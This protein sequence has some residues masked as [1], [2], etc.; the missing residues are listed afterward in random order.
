MFADSAI[1]GL[2][3]LKFFSSMSQLKEKSR[4]MSPRISKPSVTDR[5]T[6][7]ALSLGVNF[8]TAEIFRPL[9]LLRLL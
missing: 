6:V 7:A 1:S 4:K 3:V 9:M 8:T 2:L 5:T